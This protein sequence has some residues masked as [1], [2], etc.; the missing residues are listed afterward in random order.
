MRE[1][2]KKEETEIHGPGRGPRSQ[3]RLVAKGK[4]K[5]RKT[6]TMMT[7]MIYRKARKSCLSSCL[8]TNGIL[9]MDLIPLG[10]GSRRSSM[11]FGSLVILSYRPQTF[12]TSLHRSYYDGRQM[13][14]R[15]GNPFTPPKWL[16]DSLYFIEGFV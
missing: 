6:M 14:S 9:K 3:C 10:G 11:V 7:T 4:I 12:V 1:G 8:Q 13:I 2:T 16:L 15:L 5:T